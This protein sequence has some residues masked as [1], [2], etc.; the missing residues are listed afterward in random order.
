L[1]LWSFQGARRPPAPAVKAGIARSFKTQQRGLLHVEVDVISRRARSSDGKKRAIKGA[2][3]L[4][5]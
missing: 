4:P 1:P 5:R 2:E 3:R